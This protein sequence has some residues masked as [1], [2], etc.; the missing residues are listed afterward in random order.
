MEVIQVVRKVTKAKAP[1]LDAFT[2]A[3]F[4][5]CSDIVREDF[6]KVLH[7][8]D[9]YGKFVRSLT[10]TFIVLIPSFGCDG[11]FPISLVNGV[12][13][14]I[15]KVLSCC[16]SRVME[17]NILKPQNAFVKGRQILDFV[18]IANECL[19]RKIKSEVLGIL[20]KPGIFQGC[21]HTFFFPLYMLFSPSLSQWVI[22]SDDHC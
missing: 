16:M 6:M 21:L 22:C 7:E 8:L 11:F 1:G 19:E 2:M 12:Y 18:L 3:F 9:S 4:H 15:S 14:I 13:K 17:M 10:K 5:A 20:C